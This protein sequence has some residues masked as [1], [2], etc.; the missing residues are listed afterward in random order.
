VLELA[1]EAR[2]G[3]QVE[4]EFIPDDALNPYASARHVAAPAGT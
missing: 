3:H 2:V 1:V 4:L